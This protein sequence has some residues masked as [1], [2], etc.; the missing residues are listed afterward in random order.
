MRSQM[1]QGTQ[2]IC[3]V[4]IPSGYGALGM[5]VSSCGP[6]P[7]CLCWEGDDHCS[8][9]GLQN[10]LTF[11]T[12]RKECSEWKKNVWEHGDWLRNL[13]KI[14]FFSPELLCSPRPCFLLCTWSTDVLSRTG[15]NGVSG[16]TVHCWSAS[17][18]FLVWFVGL[19]WKGSGGE[20]IWSRNMA[21]WD[22]LRDDRSSF[23]VKDSSWPC[24][25]PAACLSYQSELK[26]CVRMNYS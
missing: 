19:D 17:L 24:V 8:S 20:R 11:K 22:P 13:C 25:I 3:S 2:S 9:F 7:P 26:Y 1:V 16:H 12:Q 4:W 10:S 14:L 6:R 5:P 23:L 18:C 15:T 21:K